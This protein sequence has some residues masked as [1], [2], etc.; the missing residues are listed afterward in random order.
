MKSPE[1]LPVHLLLGVVSNPEGC[2]RGLQRCNVKVP[3]V[4]RAVEAFLKAQSDTEAEAGPDRSPLVGMFLESK[5]APTAKAALPKGSKDAPFSK[6][7]QKAFPLAM[8]VSDAMTSD[9]VRSEHVLWA[10]LEDESVVDALSLV[11]DGSLAASIKTELDVDL[12]SG[13]GKAELVGGAPKTQTPALAE[14]GV[15]LTALARSG[16]LDPVAGRANEVTRALQILVRRRKSNPCFIGDPGVGKTAIAEGIAQRIASGD[17]PK[18]LRD[19]RVVSLELSNLVAGTRYRGDFEEKLKAILTEVAAESEGPLGKIILFIDELHTLV[20]AGAAEGGIDAANVLK[21]ALARGELQVMGATTVSEYRQYIEKDAALERRFQ[22]ILVG[23][24]SVEETVEILAKI[25]PKYEEYHGVTYSDDALEAAAKLSWRYVPDRFLPDKAIDL[26]DEAGAA[27]QFGYAKDDED[28]DEAAMDVTAEDV[29]AVV[30]TWTGI[31]VTA[32]SSDESSSLLQLEARLHERVI[33]QDEAAQAIGRAVRRARVGLSSPTRPVASFLFSGPTGVGKTELAKA[34]AAEYYGEEKAMI[35]L[36]MSEY[37]ESFAV[38]RLTGPPPGYVGYEA[39]GQLTEAVRRRPHAV[40]LLDEIEKAHPDVYNILLQILDDGRLTDNKG[41]TIDFTN[42]LLIMTSNLGSRA[43]LERMGARPSSGGGGATSGNKPKKPKGGAAAAAAVAVAA[44]ASA[45]EDAA[46]EYA[47]MQKV[48]KR[49]LLGHFRPEFLNRL[50]E[51]IVFRS[52]VDDELR[53]VAALMVAAV[54]KRTLDT[55]DL[56]LMVGPGLTQRLLA[57]GSSRRFGARPLR[58]T[59]QR[60]VED[61]V[62]VALLQGFATSGDALTLDTPSAAQAFADAD[63]NQDGA[64]SLAE[65]QQ[66]YQADD[67]ARGDAKAVVVARAARGAVAAGVL[68]VAVSLSVGIE[69]TEDDEP[70]PAPVRALAPEAFTPEALTA[71]QTK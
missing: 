6:A 50:D 69:D 5:G 31:P 65:F 17:C 29:A 47:A 49:E 30:S 15:D 66:W 3:D 40:L 19:C 56:T 53:E 62:A 18:R 21:P 23:E 58:R 39:G 44:A 57:E 45:V 26:V 2:Y 68:E 71:A 12:E 43:I 55:H 9:V 10:L 32:L 20:G 63:A 7:V 22:P 25:R 4:T 61:V 51:I 60:L 35:R 38:S 13:R 36:D 59:V 52:L 24:P 37:M 8:Q 34:L 67:G 48:V 41:R 27:K 42:V 28:A 16:K 70:E 33:G 54:A 1:L 64:V 11:G 14:C 46:T